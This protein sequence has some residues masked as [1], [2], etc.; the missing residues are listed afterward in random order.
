MWL[1]I[2][3]KRTFQGTTARTRSPAAKPSP[4]KR[5]AWSS[6]K[7]Y[8]ST[9]LGARPVLL[10]PALVAD[11]AAALRV[12]GRFAQLGE[13]EPV[14]EL[15]ERADLREDVELLVADELG[16]R[17][18]PPGETRPRARCRAPARRPARSRG[19]LP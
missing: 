19:A 13:E 14:L 16:L 8:A 15:L 11:L 7:R 9:Q 12:E 18:P 1:A 4:S 10:D 2:V 6:P 17:S 3:G 5:S